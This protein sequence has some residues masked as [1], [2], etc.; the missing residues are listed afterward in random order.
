MS[1]ASAQILSASVVSPPATSAAANATSAAAS[2]PRFRVPAR[3]ARRG[4]D[5]AGDVAVLQLG[6]PPQR[7]PL[8]REEPVVDGGESFEHRGRE[9]ERV[10]VTDL[11]RERHAQHGCELSHG[12]VRHPARR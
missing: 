6:E 2:G 10:G 7:V 11:D 1:S 9:L 3:A 8:V 4:V 5:R 12:M